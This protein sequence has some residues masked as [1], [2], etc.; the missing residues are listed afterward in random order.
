MREQDY[1]VW[2]QSQG[3]N[4]NT[5]A[6]QLNRARRIEREYGDLDA[7][8]ALDECSALNADFQYSANDEK[9]GRGN[10]SKFHFG[11][12]N[13]RSSLSTMR[14]ALSYYLKFCASEKDVSALHINR[15]ALEEY[16]QIFLQNCGDFQ[17]FQQTSGFYYENERSYKD[18]IIDS[19]AS[20]MQGAGSENTQTIGAKLFKLLHDE[21]KSFV[22]WRTFYNIEASYNDVAQFEVERIIGEMALSEADV[23]EAI[24]KAARE[25]HPI[26]KDNKSS[27]SAYGQL[28]S[29]VTTAM[30][31]IKPHKAIPVKTS[32][33]RRVWKQLFGE[34]IMKSKIIDEME[35]NVLTEGIH[36]IHRIL[37][38]EW[39][40]QPRDLWDVQGFLWVVHYSA[41]DK[42]ENGVELE[43]EV[44]S[45]GM[46]KQ[47]K[48]K[49]P[50]NQIL[51]GP[52]GTG[53]TYQ[54]ARLAVEICDGEVPS[55][56]IEI[57][58]RYDELLAAKRI[59]FTTFHQSIGYEE[60]VEGLRPV[61]GGEDESASESSVGFRL[62]PQ[63]GI[64]REICALANQ[65]TKQTSGVNDIDLSNKRFFK[66][67]L[68]DAK[69]ESHI[70]DAAIEGDFIT[71]GWG[72]EVDWSEINAEFPK[73]FHKIKERW[74]KINPEASSQDPNIT[75]SF[76]FYGNMRVGDIVVISD[77]NLRF[78]AIA[79][80]TGEYEFS[81]HDS[82]YNHR[83]TVKWLRVFDESLPASNIVSNKL[84]QVS[85]YELK[86]KNIKLDAFKALLPSNKIKAGGAE[87]HVLII[88]EI[89][90]ANISKVLGELITLLEPD[91]RLGQ[92]N[93]IKL[94]LP[95]SADEFGVPSNLHIIGTMN[96]ADRSIA[97]LD[98]ALRRRFDFTEVMPDYSVI[99]VDVDDIN[100]AE[101]LSAMNE[102]VEWLFDR[103]HQ[104]GH[105]YFCDVKSKAELDHVM[106]HKIIPL[107][108]EYF[109][110][111]WEKV[112]A[113]LNDSAGLFI[114][115]ETLKPPS[116][117][118]DAFEERKRYV[119]QP[120]PFDEEAYY[121]VVNR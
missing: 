37:A 9:E 68:G 62:E 71:L 111:D 18:K 90:R 45:S 17:N 108:A 6:S 40:W 43:E 47:L 29:L 51:Y 23:S 56:R 64:F 86:L 53:K 65:A 20:I 34:T 75:Q 49:Y 32:Y 4:D 14:A 84:S 116:T 25:I 79:E 30:A 52:P 26:L 39:G 41:D 119:L 89:N 69:T 15:Q 16:K 117:L 19:A 120:L 85:C 21:S 112:I 11:T 55:E 77:G 81:P 72:G 35:Y 13:L 121:Q 7:A 83:R 58:K 60:F 103:E 8:F 96:T 106:A 70:Y 87:N 44:E 113:V 61:T 63:N 28:R 5:I 88:D 100:L 74:L 67:S 99:D 48:S 57:K 27:N 118:D 10:P 73:D 91:K 109:F 98:T 22:G 92:K 93:E 105:S 82:G 114:K 107:I 101:V 46:G 104:I 102:R 97:Q 3:L 115:R 12:E 33:M 95:Y 38:E 94:T 54:T 110:E 80:I 31:I 1:K 76:T 2:L 42:K 50:L 66:M 78:R 24:A 59:A 36:S